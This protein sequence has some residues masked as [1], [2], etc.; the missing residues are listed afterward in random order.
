MYAHLLDAQTCPGVDLNLE[1]VTECPNTRSYICPG[2]MVQYECGND[3]SIA[4]IWDEGGDPDPSLFNCPPQNFISLLPGGMNVVCDAVNGTIINTA[5]GCFRTRVMF[6][7]TTS[8]NGTMVRC[9]DGSSA[10]VMVLGS[11]E[12]VIVGT[13][14][15]KEC[16]HVNIHMYTC[17]GTCSCTN[18]Y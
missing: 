10:Q 14:T 17:T 15:I 8:L 13:L 18:N 12:V 9:R 16:R 5:D 11:D 1:D 6:E 4:T 3:L 2:E 7:A